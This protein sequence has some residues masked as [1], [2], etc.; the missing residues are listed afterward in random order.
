MQ[1]KI[2]PRGDI[3]NPDESHEL[4]EFEAGSRTS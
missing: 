2:V 3:K 1:A 4:I